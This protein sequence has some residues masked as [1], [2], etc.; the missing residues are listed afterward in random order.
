M[1][2]GRV[3]EI[4]NMTWEEFKKCFLEYYEEPCLQYK[5]VLYHFA[6]HEENGQAVFEFNYETKEHKIVNETYST[7]E[8]LLLNAKIDGKTIQEIWDDLE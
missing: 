2:Q 8:S 1:K 5:G 6:H 4:S 7:P 3:I